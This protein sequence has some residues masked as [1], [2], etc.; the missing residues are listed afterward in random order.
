VANRLEFG[1]ATEGV[2]QVMVRQLEDLGVPCWLA[3]VKIQGYAV[4]K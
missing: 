2:R 4:P 1:A 3:G